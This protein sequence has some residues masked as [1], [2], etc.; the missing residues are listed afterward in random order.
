MGENDKEIS[1]NMEEKWGL[2]FEKWLKYS[3]CFS[4]FGC[5]ILSKQVNILPDVSIDEKTDLSF[6]VCFWDELK[7]CNKEKTYQ[8]I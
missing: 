4:T 7:S 8:F 3:V 2:P 1:N 6:K 5:Y